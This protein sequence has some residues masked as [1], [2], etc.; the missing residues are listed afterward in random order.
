MTKLF[1]LIK[2]AII[3]LSGKDSADFPT[4]QVD[5]LGKTKEIELVFPYGLAANPKEKCFTLLFSVNGQEDNILGI[6][7]N[8][9]NRFKN[10]TPGEVVVGNSYVNTKIYFKADGTIEIFT[11]KTLNINANNINLGS[12]GKAIARKDDEVVGQ[13]IIPSG[14]S[15]GTYNITNGKINTGSTKHT[16]N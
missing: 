10:L 16:C 9:T 7:H 8:P 1:N 15:A 5:Y 3:S 6:A 14:S 2:N 4:A 11:D 13:V 12:S